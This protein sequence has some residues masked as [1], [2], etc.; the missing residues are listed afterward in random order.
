MV[1]VYT[2]LHAICVCMS[3][4]VVLIRVH[5]N[6]EVLLH[7]H[8]NCLSSSLQMVEL[9]VSLCPRKNYFILPVVLKG[10]GDRSYHHCL[11]DEKRR[12]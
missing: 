6:F 4:K 3:T 8:K 7:S 2:V 11:T 10:G 12:D 5:L 9:W 1:F